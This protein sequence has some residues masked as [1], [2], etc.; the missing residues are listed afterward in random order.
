MSIGVEVEIEDF[1]DAYWNC[2]HCD[3]EAHKEE[4]LDKST[5]SCT[6]G[7]PGLM[8]RRILLE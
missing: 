4:R 5:V 1:L 3:V 7:D 6:N 2:G 8:L